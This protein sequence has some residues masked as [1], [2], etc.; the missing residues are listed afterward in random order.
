METGKLDMCPCD[1]KEK[2]STYKTVLT[3]GCKIAELSIFAIGLGFNVGIGHFGVSERL[4]RSMVS[5]TGYIYDRN[6]DLYLLTDSA[7]FNMRPSS[8][9][10]TAIPPCVFDC[11]QMPR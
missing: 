11:L 2:C 4:Q 7:L 8:F 10:S 5:G 9:I 6:S 3:L 1:L